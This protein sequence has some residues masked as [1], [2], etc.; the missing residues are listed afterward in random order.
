MTV[1]TAGLL[2]IIVPDEELAEYLPRG[3][4]NKDIQLA[5][6]RAHPESRKVIHSLKLLVLPYWALKTFSHRIESLL[7]S[8]QVRSGKII[9]YTVCDQ[10][11]AH[12]IRVN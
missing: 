11:V 10:M 2:K 6:Y 12:R 5:R 7:Q 8:S 9:D 1:Y 4:L 3:K